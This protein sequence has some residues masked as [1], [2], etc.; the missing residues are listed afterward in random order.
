M[1]LGLPYIGTYAAYGFFGLGFILVLVG[2]VAT[3]TKSWTH[4]DNLDDELTS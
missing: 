4:Y 3:I 2:I 1:A